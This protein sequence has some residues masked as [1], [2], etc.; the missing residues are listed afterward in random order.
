LPLSVILMTN[1][2]LNFDHLVSTP[3]T[4]RKSYR[5]EMPIPQEFAPDGDGSILPV[6]IHG[7]AD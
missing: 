6:D 3:V 5:A 4:R 2:S 7:R 1:S